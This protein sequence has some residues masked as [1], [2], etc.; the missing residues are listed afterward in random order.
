MTLYKNEL[1]RNSFTDSVY[2][3]KIDEEK[4]PDFSTTITDIY[5]ERK[6]TFSYMKEIGSQHNLNGQI[7]SQLSR[8]QNRGELHYYADQEKQP[9]DNYGV[10]QYDN[11][12]ETLKA[13]D[14]SRFYE[15]LNANN[16]QSM[17]KY[18]ME[19]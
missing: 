11:D 10:N 18:Y 5:G 1:K 6:R 9:N 19:R 17:I 2:G 3:S 4:V 15:S 13:E 7:Q 16:D 8:N 12:E 14:E